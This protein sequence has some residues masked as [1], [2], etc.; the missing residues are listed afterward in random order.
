[1]A[2]G[3][4]PLCVRCATPRPWGQACPNPVCEAHNRPSRIGY[5]GTA[6]DG[7]DSDSLGEEGSTPGPEPIERCACSESLALRE[8]LKVAAAHVGELLL[9]FDERAMADPERATKRMA[10]R[11][12]VTDYIARNGT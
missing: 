9:N 1:M 11:A 5:L 3:R 8:Q 2:T 4:I 7:G 10:A 6:A 12:W